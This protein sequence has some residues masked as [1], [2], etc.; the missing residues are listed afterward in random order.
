MVDAPV[1]SAH[2]SRHNH[3]PLGCF[4]SDVQHA[5]GISTV[6][7]QPLVAP[8]LSQG[9]GA[10]D[11]VPSIRWSSVSLPVPSVPV[12]LVNLVYRGHP[13]IALRGNAYTLIC[14]YRFSRAPLN[15]LLLRPSPPHPARAAS[16]STATSLSGYTP[17]TLLSDNGLQ[18]CSKL[19]RA[20]YERLSIKK[21]SFPLI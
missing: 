15:A 14:A 21:K 16:S 11:F 12:I 13:P 2:V 10:Q 18:L 5:Y 4:S 8:P 3:L 7:L 9:P 20:I 19:S 17:A 6:G 1:G